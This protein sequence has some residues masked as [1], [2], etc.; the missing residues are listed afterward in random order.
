MTTNGRYPFAHRSA[1]STGQF[2][3][4]ALIIAAVL[5]LIS[6]HTF[7]A[8]SELGIEESE[9]ALQQTLEQLNALDKWLTQ[10]EQDNNQLIAQLREQDKKIAALTK[11]TQQ[12]NKA[13]AKANM[14]LGKTT[15]EI[16]ALK[17]SQK[18]QRQAVAIH[19]RAAYRLGGDDFIKQLLNKNSSADLDRLIRYHGYF[20]TE[21]LAL[22]EGYKNSLQQLAQSEKI[23][24]KQKQQRDDHLTALQ[25]QRANMSSERKARERSIS[26]LAAQKKDKTQQQKTLLA[27]SERLQSL[28]QTLQLEPLGFDDSSIEEAKGSLPKPMEGKLRNRFGDQRAGGRLQWRGFTMGA[29]LGTPVTAVFRG[30]VVFADWLRGFGFMTIIDHGEGYMTMYGFCDNLSKKTG[31]WVESGETIASA[32]NSGGQQEP[33][34]YFELRHEGIVRDPAKWINL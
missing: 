10:A 6:P 27:D 12:A 26:K 3:K 13:L 7:T 24:S 21:R 20:G 22:I 25:Q 1:K 34:M 5:L 15:N 4:M 32:G 23:L 9:L 2:R 29:E 17:A 30:R 8:E 19:L 18:Q 16:D 31:D 33:G 14:A 28:I 11:Q